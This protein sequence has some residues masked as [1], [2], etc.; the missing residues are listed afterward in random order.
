MAVETDVFIPQFSAE[1]VDAIYAEVQSTEPDKFRESER[2]AMCPQVA[3]FHHD[4]FIAM[5]SRGETE[6][7]HRISAG[8]LLGHRVLRSATGADGLP[9]RTR[10][11]VRGYAVR[12]F[13]N[14]QLLETDFLRDYT[15]YPAVTSLVAG[16][17]FA[18]SKY[19][20]RLLLG[21]YGDW[22]NPGRLAISLPPEPAAVPQHGG[23]SRPTRAT[24]HASK[25]RSLGR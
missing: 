16:L 25:Q 22:A 13:N 8:I 24:R 11:E 3:L 6:E 4:K 9:E 20:A 21:M 14:Q 23:L 12:V 5:A 7:A 18:S 1:V 19:G 2:A 10:H 15:E 17:R